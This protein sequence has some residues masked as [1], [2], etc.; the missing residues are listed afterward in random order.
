[1]V[2]PLERRVIV[3]VCCRSSLIHFTWRRDIRLVAS[4]GDLIK[5]AISLADV[6]V[7]TRSCLPLVARVEHGC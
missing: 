5:Q 6:Q 2:K 4:K 3:L 7:L 1:M